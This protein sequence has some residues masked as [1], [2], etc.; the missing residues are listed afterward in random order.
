MYGRGIRQ[1]IL[2]AERLL[3]GKPAPQGELDPRWQAI[4]RV[5]EFIESNPDDVWKFAL[6][7]GKHAQADVRAAVAT[8]LLEHLLE[9]HFASMFPRVREA[10]EASR[11]FA[12]TLRM[13]WHFGDAADPA[14][15][16][17]LA[18]LIRRTS[19]R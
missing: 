9:H 18:R 3:P 16:R 1:A 5:G 6:R 2:S 13:V 8:C 14:N 17:T 15:R 11:R 7:W 19:R 4:I 12:D 10:A